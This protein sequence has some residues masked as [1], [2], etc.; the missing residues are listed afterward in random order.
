MTINLCGL[1]IIFGFNS[2][3]E[4]LVS[5]AVGANQFENCGILLNRGRLVVLFA[6]IPII[7]ILFNSQS[8]LVAFG[9]NLEVAQ[10]AQKYVICYIPGLLLQAFSDL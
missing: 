8:I 4:S 3:I 6:F 5:R 10:Y 9:Q 7:I 1:S 2:A